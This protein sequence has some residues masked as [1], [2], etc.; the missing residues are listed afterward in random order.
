MQ[1][2]HDIYINLLIWR[3]TPTEGLDSSPAQRLFGHRTRTDMPTSATLLKP[4]LVDNVKQN[5]ERMKGKQETNYNK[6]AQDL[7]DLNVGD[8]VRVKLHSDQKEWERAKLMSNPAIR[9]YVVKTADGRLYRRN[10]RQLKQTNETFE[11]EQL[12]LPMDGKTQSTR[13]NA[14]SPESADNKVQLRRSNRKR[15][16]PKYLKDYVT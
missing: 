2:W 12:Y 8:S 13:K 11:E 15:Q 9:S 5:K 1:R 6:G 4:Q 3:N 10:R 14:R 7:S 16:K